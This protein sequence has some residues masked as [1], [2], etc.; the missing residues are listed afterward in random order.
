MAW[1]VRGLSLGWSSNLHPG[2]FYFT[3]FGSVWAPDNVFVS[4][5]VALELSVFLS[6][7]RAFY[8]L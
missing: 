6:L 1:V 8:S 5:L 3:L 4:I 2:L 7:V